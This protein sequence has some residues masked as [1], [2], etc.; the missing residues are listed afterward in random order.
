MAEFKESKKNK[1]AK[2]KEIHCLPGEIYI[3]GY[4]RK[5]GVEVPGHCRIRS[6]IKDPLMESFGYKSV[7]S[8]RMT[9]NYRKHL[10]KLREKYYEENR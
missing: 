8:K 5:D 4:T 7:K 6:D 3:E 1:S 10:E 2:R 9:A